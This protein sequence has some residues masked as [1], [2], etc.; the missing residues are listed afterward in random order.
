MAIIMLL[1][2]LIVGAMIQLPSGSLEVILAGSIVVIVT[3]GLVIAVVLPYAFFASLGRGYLLPIAL[4]VLTVITAN[5]VMALGW[6]DYFPWAVPTLYAQ[7]SS[8]LTP[9]SYA[10]VFVTSLIGMIVTY[11]WWKY[12]DQNR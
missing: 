4:A 9:A 1:F 12:A 2:G 5:L 3:I 7:D 11:L 8:S 6:A 10:I